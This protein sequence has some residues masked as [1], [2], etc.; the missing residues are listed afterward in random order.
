MNM[1]TIRYFLII[2]SSYEGDFIGKLKDYKSMYGVQK[3]SLKM[4]SQVN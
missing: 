4:T 3:M 1:Y 2:L